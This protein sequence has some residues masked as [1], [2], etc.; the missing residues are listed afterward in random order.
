MGQ[1]AGVFGSCGRQGCSNPGY[2][3]ARQRCLPGGALNLRFRRNRFP[4]HEV[5]L[6]RIAA[7]C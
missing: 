3:R 5:S 1:P 6:K 2:R 7:I 4:R